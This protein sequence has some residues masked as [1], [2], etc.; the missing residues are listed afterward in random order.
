MNLPF[1]CVLSYLCGSIPFGLLVSKFFIKT[2]VRSIGSG[3]IGATNVLRLGGKKYALLTVFFDI[4]KGIIP[5]L[6][7]ADH[8]PYVAFF[9]VV[10]H[11]FPI[12]LKFKGGKG[13]AT[14]IGTYIALWPILGFFLLGFWLL[15]SK[16]RRQSSFSS[17][18]TL[19]AGAIL[20]FHSSYY[21]LLIFVLV[22]WTHKDNL[23][24]LKQKKEP[25]L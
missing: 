7:T 23:K 1:S 6:M 14:S 8:K 20:S 22:L 4:A 15:I 11:I 3:N 13:V 21:G 16:I 10:G 9:A 24:R 17:I 12:W 25:Y 2:D 5:V 18:L 19:F